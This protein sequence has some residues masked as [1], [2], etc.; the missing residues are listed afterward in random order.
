MFVRGGALNH[1]E[2][3][4]YKNP[5]IQRVF[6]LY[7]PRAG[8]TVV[9]IFGRDLQAGASSQVL[10]G[11][12]EIVCDRSTITDSQVTCVTR[13][14]AAT[15]ASALSVRMRYDNAERVAPAPGSFM[16]RNN[17]LIDSV[18]PRSVFLSGGRVITVTGSDLDVAQLPQIKVMR[19]NEQFIEVRRDRPTVNRHQLLHVLEVNYFLIFLLF[20][21]NCT[22]V[23]PAEL[24]CLSP[25]IRTPLSRRRR[26]ASPMSN[27]FN[28]TFIMDGVTDFFAPQDN[29]SAA[30]SSLLLDVFP[31]PSFELFDGGVKTYV[32]S[33]NSDASL[34]ING[35]NLTLAATTSEYDVTVGDEVCTVQTVDTNI[36]FCIPPRKKES[37]ASSRF[38]VTVSSRKSDIPVQC[39]K[40]SR[41]S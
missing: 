25:Q 8:G 15:P 39:K 38:P 34:E 12:E 29:S 20:L 37:E 22:I 30:G 28:L 26:Q 2:Q 16:Y 41:L 6:P 7:G 23:S 4:Q 35:A 1:D 14:L 33:D 24:R 10:F 21:Q 19:D 40:Q 31:D 27:S 5:E 9:T 17:P 32:V 11:S 36:L 18:E 3:F 13:A